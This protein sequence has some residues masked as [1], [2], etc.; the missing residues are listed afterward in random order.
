MFMVYPYARSVK[1]DPRGGKGQGAFLKVHQNIKVQ[2]GWRPLPVCYIEA[3]YICCLLD[4]EISKQSRFFSTYEQ[5]L[6]MT[7]SNPER[8]MIER[9]LHWLNA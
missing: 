8:E 5:M 7:L 3:M 2:T 6:K 9:S 1:S 4:A